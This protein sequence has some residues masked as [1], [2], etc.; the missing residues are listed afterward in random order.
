[1][2]VQG[3]SRSAGRQTFAGGSLVRDFGFSVRLVLGRQI[4][5]RVVDRSSF[6]SEVPSGQDGPRNA[7]DACTSSGYGTVDTDPTTA[8]KRGSNSEDHQ[9]AHRL[10]IPANR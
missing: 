5:G 4:T 2:S 3:L 7:A 9:Y 1:M 8:T 6:A 10:G